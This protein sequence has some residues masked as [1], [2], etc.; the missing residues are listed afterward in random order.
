[1]FPTLAY[2][3]T[4]NIGS[5]LPTLDYMFPTL[6]YLSTTN[7]G[8]MLPT[9]VYLSTTNIGPILPTLVYLST[10]NIGSI[11]PMLVY[12]SATNIGPMIPTLVY[13]IYQLPT[14]THLFVGNQLRSQ[15]EHTL[16][17]NHSVSVLGEYDQLKNGCK[18]D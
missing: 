10:T 11:G 6:V 5:M 1:M 12:L 7:I 4:T 8:S 3:S 2:L 15:P 17:H 16:L 14:Q 18:G 13:C 9:L